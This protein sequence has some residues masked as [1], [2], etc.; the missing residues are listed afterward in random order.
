MYPEGHPSLKKSYENAYSV[1]QRFLESER[2]LDIS[3][4]KEGL[5]NKDFPLNKGNEVIKH[6]TQDMNMKSVSNLTFKNGLTLEEFNSF[7]NLFAMEHSQFREAGGAIKLFSE[8]GIKLITV[9][10]AAFDGLIKE[11]YAEEGAEEIGE[12][13]E[14]VKVDIEMP[15]EIEEEEEEDKELVEEIER[16]IMLLVKETNPNRIKKILINIIKLAGELTAQEKIDY[17]LKLLTAVSK[18]AHPRRRRPKEI[19]Q[20]CVKTVRKCATEKVI[21]GALDNFGKKDEKLRNELGI[22]IKVI[23]D[24]T[25]TPALELLI[26][27]EDS[28]IRRNLIKLIVSF[29]EMARPKV[30][31]LLFDNRWFVVRNMANIL[32]EIKSEKSLN[33]LSRVMNHDEIRVQREVIKALTKIGGKNVTIFFLRM[34]ENAPQQLAFIL[35]NSLGALGDA[36]AVEPLVNIA[37]TRDMF[38]R[39]F[40]IRR[41]AINSLARLGSK[42]SMDALGKI[43]LKGEFLGGIRNEELRITAAKALGKLGGEKAIGFLFKAAKKRNSNIKRA[44]LAALKALGVEI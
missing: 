11:G 42:D 16:L 15:E 27:S 37:T 26:E 4:K 40:E 18:E 7:M 20:M 36:M 8:N 34:L 2:E 22:L 13:E 10:E 19:Q 32:G 28:F 33:S 5:F 9:K 31:I 17:A 1:L 3:L 24:E 41:E 23:G 43:L 14:E 12:A 39:N 44:S 6:L 35:I 29:G 38:Y 25:I 30:E 21:K